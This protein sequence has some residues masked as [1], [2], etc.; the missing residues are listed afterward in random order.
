MSGDCEKTVLRRS[1]K[2]AGCYRVLTFSDVFLAVAIVGEEGRVVVRWWGGGGADWVV[3][4]S[5]SFYLGSSGSRSDS[6]F[7]CVR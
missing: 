1:R 5:T 7:V 4:A 3:V 6:R 2:E